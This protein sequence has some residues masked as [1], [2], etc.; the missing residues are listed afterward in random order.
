[1]LV[2]FSAERQLITNSRRSVI[3]VIFLEKIIWESLQLSFRFCRFM[4]CFIQ[5]SEG[6]SA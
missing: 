1:M 6:S 3:L 2:L 4:K 5:V